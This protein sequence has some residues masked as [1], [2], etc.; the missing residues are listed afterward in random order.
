MEKIKLL[1]ISNFFCGLEI[2]RIVKNLGRN[3]DVKIIRVSFEEI[4]ETELEHQYDLSVLLYNVD[5][6]FPDYISRLLTEQSS[7]EI[8]GA[9][10]RQI[11]K[12]L[13][14]IASHSNRTYIGVDS[15]HWDIT[16]KVFSH[17]VTSLKDGDARLLSEIYQC[18]GD[19][20][21]IIDLDRITMELG[22]TQIYDFKKYYRW[23]C[24]YSFEFFNKLFGDL[25]QAY[26]I[27]QGK[28]KK[29]IVLD[30]DNVLWG[31]EIAEHGM[32]KI[33]LGSIGEGK[34]YQDFQHLVKMLQQLGIVLCLCS[35]NDE[36]DIRTVFDR[37]SAMILKNDD[38]VNRQ[39]SWEAKWIGIT[40]ISN[41]LGI[42]LDQIVFVDDSVHEIK[43][44]QEKLPEVFCV[45]FDINH[46]WDL[47]NVIKL[48]SKYN[49]QTIKERQG[50][51]HWLGEQKVGGQG[52]AQEDY[53]R[54]LET[55][56][57]LSN[58]QEEE[59]LRIAELSQRTNRCTI[60]AR[61]SYGELK[62][63][64]SEGTHEM[65][66]VYVKDK[67]HD[68]GLMGGVMLKSGVLEFFSLSCRVLGRNVEET[69]LDRLKEKIQECRF[70]ATYKN[71][72][73]KKTLEKYKI[74]MI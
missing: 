34:K 27:S 68:F 3:Q 25:F 19:R 39:I 49:L 17:V 72:N 46:F 38:I 23:N 35:K 6:D 2:E 56:V 30:C 9:V 57:I 13:S 1:L 65:Y 67:L 53:L 52:G 26:E 73:L 66:S 45:H 14:H 21:E 37:H 54:E 29:C 18:F 44:V 64:L 33:V 12:V 74:V 63:K 20:A 36:A 70:V 40:N 31:G 22:I 48:P 5:I 59:L 28:M 11:E 7:N 47:L 32:D 24:P 42:S 62:D 15:K 51:Y 61:L 58:T 50:Y 69:I 43:Q 41:L 8:T 71:E 60:G 10:M 16:G 4:L 55:E